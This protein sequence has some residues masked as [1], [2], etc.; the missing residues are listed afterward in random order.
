MSRLVQ[1]LKAL[2]NRLVKPA[3]DRLLARLRAHMAL[4]VNEELRQLVLHVTAERV[5]LAAELTTRVAAEAATLRR[6][7]DDLNLC[8][9]GLL[10]EVVRLQRETRELS[11][12]V[13]RL[14]LE[15]RSSELLQGGGADSP[16]LQLDDARQARAA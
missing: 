1:R 10:R 5:A 4:A 9:D 14:S 2:L 12:A 6:Q 3:R 7:M 16:H 8:N 15:P 13:E 11:E